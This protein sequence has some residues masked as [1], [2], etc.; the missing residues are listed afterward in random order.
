[1][2]NVDQTNTD[3][4]EKGD[5]C[6]DDDDNDGVLDTQDNCQ[7]DANSNQSDID[8]DGAG[9]ICD[10]DAD[11]DDIS[12]YGCC[13]D[14]GERVFLNSSCNFPDICPNCGAELDKVVWD[15][16]NSLGTNPCS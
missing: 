16:Q 7:Y 12:V 3:G 4:D 15:N 1:M 14:C 9:D 10:S 2:A 13:S 11:N 6:D 8:N 5:V